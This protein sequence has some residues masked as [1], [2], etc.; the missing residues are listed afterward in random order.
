VSI[1]KSFAKL[2]RN[3]IGARRKKYLFAAFEIA[4][5]IT[6]NEE[7]AKA[8]STYY[9]FRWMDGNLKYFGGILRLKKHLNAIRLIGISLMADAEY[10]RKIRTGQLERA[11]EI[12]CLTETRKAE[13]SETET[14]EGR[15]RMRDKYEAIAQG[16]KTW[17][18]E[19]LQEMH[20]N[21]DMIEVKIRD[22]LLFLKKNPGWQTHYDRLIKY[23]NEYVSLS[24]KH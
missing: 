17:A 2:G 13:L 1:E 3:R 22:D 18:R 12:D 7:D 14:A 6:E 19:M 8:L 20:E 10:L 11:K 21:P 4:K 5:G 9:L 23:F 15:G 16:R 24:K